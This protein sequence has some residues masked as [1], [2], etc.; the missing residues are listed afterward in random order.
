MKK[1]YIVAV[2]VVVLIAA[3]IGATS[4][5]QQQQASKSEAIANKSAA[6]LERDYAATTGDPNAKVT[7]VEFFDPACETCKVFHPFVKQIMDENP[8]K[9]RL[10]MR[11]AP[12]HVG[13]D[14][15][16]ALLEAAKQQGKFWETLEATYAAQPVWASHGNPQPKRLWMRL[17]GVGLNM[18]KAQKTMQSPEVL[19]NIQQDI[20]DGRQLGVSKTPSFFVNGKPLVRFGYEPLRNLIETELRNAY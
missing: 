13:S 1:S 19:K 14:Y 16:V 2:A 18:K 4:V 11:Y 10:V 9:I 8:G 20:A 17:S 3:F 12:L 6:L 5:Y 7:I 15:V